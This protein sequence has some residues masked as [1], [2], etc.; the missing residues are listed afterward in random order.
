MSTPLY[1][2]KYDALLAFLDFSVLE[3]NGHFVRGLTKEQYLLSYEGTVTHTG[4][5][6]LSDDNKSI[7]NGQHLFLLKVIYLG[8]QIR[9]FDDTYGSVVAKMA[10]QIIALVDAA[11]NQ[12]IAHAIPLPNKLCNTEL[13][14]AYLTLGGANVVNYR[15]AITQKQVVKNETIYNAIGSVA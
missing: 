7:L 6:A 8:N 1:E 12:T 4:D 14:G 5:Y 2:T 9:I 11:V 15:D 10:K 3:S 13:L